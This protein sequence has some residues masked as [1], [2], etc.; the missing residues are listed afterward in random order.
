MLKKSKR[1]INIGK[2]NRQKSA[3]PNDVKKR[4]LDAVRIFRLRGAVPDT[5][6]RARYRLDS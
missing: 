1:R 3:K 5:N 6:I 4:S 2:A